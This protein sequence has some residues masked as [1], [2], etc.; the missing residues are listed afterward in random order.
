[1]PSIDP[2]AHALVPVDS[3]AAEQLGAPNYDEFQSDREVWDLLEA[4]PRSVLRVTMPHCDA[5]SPDEIG[6]EHDPA[7]LARATA[8]MAKLTAS[9][10]TRELRNVLFVYEVTSPRLP[11]IRQIGLGGMARTNEIRTA[12][13]PGGSIIRNEGIRESKAR[14]RAVLV[15]ATLTDM[16]TVNNAVDDASG[17]FEAGLIEYAE[18]HAPD[19][20]TDDEVGDVHRVWLIGDTAT[21]ARLQGLLA[22]EPRAYV[23]DGNHRSAA[24]AMLGYRNFLTVFFPARTMT[25]A[26]YNRLLEPGVRE[27]DHLA[28][29]LAPHFTVEAHEGHDAYQP[30]VTHNVGLYDGRQ[31]WRLVPKPGTWNPDDAAEDIDAD[32]VQRHLF[33]RVFGIEDARDD[34]LTFVGANRDASWLQAQVDSGEF[35]YAV[36]LPPVT[37]AQFVRICLQDKLMPPKSTWFIPKIR[38]G[39]VMALLTQ[40]RGR[41]DG[42]EEPLTPNP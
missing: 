1:M 37:M 10:L 42:Q 38:S 33:A 2:I 5:S 14:G 12:D 3:D 31:W 15:E 13:T 20:V 18:S 27:L 29:A 25:I 4:R 40:A 41:K 32:I 9:P 35:R 39:L 11:G 34:R 19:F 7:T 24:A 28:E 26:P 23:A 22:N 16:G 6:D 8:N 17:A 21:I 36:T 30:V